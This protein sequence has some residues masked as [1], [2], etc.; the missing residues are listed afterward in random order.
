MVNWESV[1]AGIPEDSVLRQQCSAAVPRAIAAYN[2]L[3]FSEA[4]DATLTI[5]GRANRYLEECAPWT[6]LKKVHP[7]FPLPL[8]LD[9]LQCCSPPQPK[10]DIILDSCLDEKTALKA[11]DA[12]QLHRAQMSDSL[13]A[14]RS[15][16]AVKTLIDFC[17]RESRTPF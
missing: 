11:S 16:S 12:P 13:D 10:F 4:L 2:A 14:H 3:E 17:G 6:L 7:L 1:I 15:P 9:A 5:S 8:L